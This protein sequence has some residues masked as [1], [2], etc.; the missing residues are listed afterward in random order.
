[1]MKRFFVTVAAFALAAC[2]N[3]QLP[4]RDTDPYANPFYAKYLNTGSAIDA[5]ITKTLDALRANPKSPTLH[6]D[7]GQL[8]IAKGFP[9]DAERE[10]ERS[11]NAD[12]HF[13]PAWYNLG[14]VRAANGDESGAR[15][16]FYRTVALK[17]GHSNALFQLGLIEEHQGDT[18]AA[19]DLY[20]KAYGINHAL[21]DVQYN[22]R[23]LDS[24]LTHLALIKL[25]PKEHNRATMQFAR[26]PSGYKDT[27]AVEAVSPQPAPQQIVTPAPPATDQGAQKPPH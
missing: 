13:Y 26:T 7:L 14:L 18:Q 1:M 20:A 8:L 17:P 3:I 11:V 6:N 12:R 23:I 10:F 22:P 9:K 25:Y 19:V 5:Q 24:H 21:L 16:A 4:H 15:R 2:S 27:T